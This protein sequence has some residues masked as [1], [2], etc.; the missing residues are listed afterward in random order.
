[1]I[2]GQVDPCR[3]G[4]S[5]Y[6]SGRDRHRLSCDCFEFCG[7]GLSEH[8]FGSAC[9]RSELLFL[10]RSAGRPARHTRVCRGRWCAAVFPKAIVTRVERAPRFWPAEPEHHDYY[11][12]NSDQP[13]C[14]YVVAP[15]ITKFRSHFDLRRWPEGSR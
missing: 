12:N 3:G 2:A 6:V 1:M 15:K 7:E 8:R 4:A 11:V 5:R 9:E 14:Q 13:Y 10:F